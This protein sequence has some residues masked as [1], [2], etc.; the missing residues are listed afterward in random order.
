MTTPGPPPSQAHEQSA[1]AQEQAQ[2]VQNCVIYFSI[3]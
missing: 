2:M 1:G 3:F